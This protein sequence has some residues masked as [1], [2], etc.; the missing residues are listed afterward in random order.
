MSGH[1][2]RLKLEAAVLT[3]LRSGGLAH[4]SARAVAAEAG[5]NQ[6]LI[7]YHYDTINNLLHRAAVASVE[8]AIQRYRTTLDAAESFAELFAAGVTLNELERDAGNVKIMAQLVSGAQFDEQIGACARECLTLWNQAIEPAVTRLTQRS[9][10][11]GLVEP[12]GLTR[13]ITSAF[14]GLELFEG[15]DPHQARNAANSLE[16]LGHVLAAIDTLN[17]VTQRAVRTQLR[18]RVNRTGKHQT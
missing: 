12:S 16:Q 10:L 15:A 3:T 13:A 18:R 4:L 1:A 5:V 8:D 11:G 2:T 14:I 6:A 17:P 9:P 7:F